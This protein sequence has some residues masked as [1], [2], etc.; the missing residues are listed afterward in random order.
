MTDNYFFVCIDSNILPLEVGNRKWKIRWNNEGIEICSSRRG[1]WHT[2]ARHVATKKSFAKPS[3]LLSFENHPCTFCVVLRLSPCTGPL[4]NRHSESNT[5]KWGNRP[6]R[7]IHE[8]G[9]F[10]T[11]VHPQR[12]SL[13]FVIHC[14]SGLR[15]D[16][17]RIGYRIQHVKFLDV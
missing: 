2:L 16:N 3:S 17:E 8:H 11:V 1:S 7:F 10:V 13:R 6:K 4:C 9:L 12:L 5:D 14:P 15:K